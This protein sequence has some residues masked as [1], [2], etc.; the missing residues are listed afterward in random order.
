MKSRMYIKIQHGNKQCQALGKS[1]NYAI[2]ITITHF[3][4]NT[5]VFAK[6]SLYLYG[7]YYI[8]TQSNIL[9]IVIL[10]QPELENDISTL[11]NTLSSNAILTQVEVILNVEGEKS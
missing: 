2:I 3:L 7:L 4:K 9:I 8:E 1:R 6:Y 5:P 11:A 10:L